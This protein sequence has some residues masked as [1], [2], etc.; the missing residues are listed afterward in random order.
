MDS[1]ADTLRADLERYTTLRRSISDKKAHEALKGLIEETEQR[2][3]Q[4]E[5][6]T[7]LR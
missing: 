6:P 3:R 7:G 5:S 1:D 2:L 4:L